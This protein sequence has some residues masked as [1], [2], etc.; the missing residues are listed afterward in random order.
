MK[1]F[2]G[3]VLS[4]KMDKTAVVEVARLWKHP[5]YKKRVKKTKKYMVHDGSNKLK[6]GDVVIFSECKP[7]SKLKRFTVLE[8]KKDK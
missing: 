3:T 4:T 7:I 6:A 5:V 2:Q 8:I 1:V